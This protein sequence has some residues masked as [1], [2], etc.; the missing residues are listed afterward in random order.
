MALLLT[1]ALH[2]G[3]A[4]SATSSMQPETKGLIRLKVYEAV[5]ATWSLARQVT[6]TEPTRLG[7]DQSEDK[8]QEH[9]QHQG[10]LHQTGAPFVP[11]HS[12]RTVTGL[13]PPEPPAKVI[14]WEEPATLMW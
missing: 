14:C 8:Q 4:V 6:V 5:T 10:S 3:E 13:P 12:T 9:R 11:H 1:W 7:L 2:D